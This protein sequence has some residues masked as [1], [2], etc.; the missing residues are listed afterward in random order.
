MVKAD[1]HNFCNFLAEYRQNQVVFHF[2][3]GLTSVVTNISPHSGIY[4]N[5]YKF[6]ILYLNPE[7]NHE[8]VATYKIETVLYFKDLFHR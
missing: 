3:H 8:I 7:S 2:H 4:L 5:S 6:V 1:T